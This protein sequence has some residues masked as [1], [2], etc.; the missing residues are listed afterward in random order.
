LKKSIFETIHEYLHY[1]YTDEK[2][3]VKKIYFC[4]KNGVFDRYCQKLTY[5]SI[6]FLPKLDTPKRIWNSFA[7][8]NAELIPEIYSQKF[9]D[10]DWSELK[11]FVVFKMKIICNGNQEVYDHLTCWEATMCQ[12][13]MKKIVNLYL[14]GSGG[15]GKSTYM[16]FMANLA[17]NSGIA[18]DYADVVDK[19]NTLLKDKIVVGINEVDRILP[20]DLALLKNYSVAYPRLHREKALTKK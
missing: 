15:S 5:D 8:F 19:F 20:C 11:P 16:E 9:E 10:V 17:G 3:K 12:Y 2:G 14:I 1:F 18:L 13:P 7:G 6:E 4:G